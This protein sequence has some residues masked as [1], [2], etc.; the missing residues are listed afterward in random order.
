L[1]NFRS[2][3]IGVQR[4]RGTVPGAA[5]VPE[6]GDELHL[7]EPLEELGK[8]PSGRGKIERPLHRR[9]RGCGGVEIHQGSHVLGV[10]L[11]P[12]ELL[13]KQVEILALDPESS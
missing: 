8:A 12:P 10:F 5:S 11:P 6:E 9:L 2:A 4:G 1:I 13:G 7:A 3:E